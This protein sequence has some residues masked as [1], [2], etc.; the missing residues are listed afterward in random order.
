[1]TTGSAKEAGY[2]LAAS[3]EQNGSRFLCIVL[4][5]E[6]SDDRFLLASELL[7]TAAA[8]YTSHEI[9]RKGA[10]VKSVEI[11][12]AREKEIPLYA[13]EDLSLLLEKDIEIQKSINLR[14][15]LSAPLAAGE[16]AGELIVT[17]SDGGKYVV[18]L[19]VGEDIAEN[20]FGSSLSKVLSIWLVRTAEHNTL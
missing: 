10:K 19:V 2:C 14:E 4:D 11:S 5:A 3:M 9:V 20:S 17:A 12:G 16:K 1:M 18:E 6:T 15:K 7:S 13:A 8:S